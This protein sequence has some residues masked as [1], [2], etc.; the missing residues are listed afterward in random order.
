MNAAENLIQICHSRGIELTRNGDS[1][2]AMPESK[3]T[4][5]LQAALAENEASILAELTRLNTIEHK[6]DKPAAKGLLEV[7]E[8]ITYCK[9]CGVL[10]H[11]N[12]GNMKAQFLR[13]LPF[14]VQLE[15]LENW[16]WIINLLSPRTYGRAPAIRDMS[17]ELKT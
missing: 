14:N 8:L 16:W 3:V 15:V 17:A 13:R 7:M 12:D 9:E 6:T 11:V 10:F 4:A 1:L 5:S 2:Q